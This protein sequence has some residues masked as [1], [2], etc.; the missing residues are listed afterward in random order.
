MFSVKLS[1]YHIR[2]KRAASRSSAIINFDAINWRQFFRAR[3]NQHEKLAPESGVKFMAPV[4]GACVRGF[5][6]A[7]PGTRRTVRKATN[8]SDQI[9]YCQYLRSVPLACSYG[10]FR[11]GLLSALFTAQ[12]PQKPRIL[13]M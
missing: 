13:P 4:S 9:Y 11:A 5:T 2:M 7:D 8:V 6:I 3:Y 12:K 10:L 1:D